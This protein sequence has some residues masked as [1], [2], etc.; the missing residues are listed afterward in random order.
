M[1]LEKWC[2]RTC[3]MQSCHKPIC[4]NALSGK[5]HKAKHNKTRHACISH[6]LQHTHTHTHTAVHETGRPH[7]YKG[8]RISYNLLGTWQR[9]GIV[10]RGLRDS[11]IAKD[12]PQSRRGGGNTGLARCPTRTQ[13][14]ARDLTSF[15]AVGGGEPQTEQRGTGPRPQARTLHKSTSAFLNCVLRNPLHHFI[16][17]TMTTNKHTFPNT[18]DSTFITSGPPP[19][20][21]HTQGVGTILISP[22]Y[23]WGH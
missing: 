23:R 22:I 4:K 10:Q 9:D 8:N 2:P 5:H 6:Q 17:F 1:L 20:P 13:A 3:S 7:K 16:Q 19:L 14:P 21:Q 18:N 15:M 12:S 11:T